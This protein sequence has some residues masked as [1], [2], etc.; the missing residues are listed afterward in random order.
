MIIDAFIV[1]LINTEPFYDPKKDLLF[2]NIQDAWNHVLEISKENNTEPSIYYIIRISFP[3][4][5]DIIKSIQ[6]SADGI[7][8]YI[9]NYKILN[10]ICIY[11]ND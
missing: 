4:K 6:F 2:G 3:N 9:K 5:E 7:K 11:N 1:K 8:N 10:T